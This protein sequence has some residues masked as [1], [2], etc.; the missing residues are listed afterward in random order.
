MDQLSAPG[1]KASQS[2]DLILGVL[3]ILA[4]TYFI[5]FEIA[6]LTTGLL[7]YLPFVITTIRCIQHSYKYKKIF[8]IG[9]SLIVAGVFNQVEVPLANVNQVTVR[10]S[11]L[12]LPPFVKLHL[13][14]KTR[15]GSTLF[16]IP[17]CDFM[18]GKAIIHARL[19]YKKA[20][21]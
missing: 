17:R 13:N 6:N 2:F 9:D 15:F 1:T 18:T 4:C 14:C 21:A 12:G 7:W 10:E 3:F 5:I 20:T 11:K 19:P 8:I 16:F